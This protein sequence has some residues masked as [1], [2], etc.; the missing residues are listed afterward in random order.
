MFPTSSVILLI[1]A[2]T[3]ELAHQRVRHRV[4]TIPA[5][6]TAATGSDATSIDPEQTRRFTLQALQDLLAT[7]EVLTRELISSVERLSRAIQT[8]QSTEQIAAIGKQYLALYSKQKLKKKRIVMNLETK[9]PDLP[10]PEQIKTESW[11]QIRLY[12]VSVA[13]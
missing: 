1:R 11:Y 12:I 6:Q 7:D 13:D 2:E 3:P 10:T 8:H 5:L 9:S 4:N